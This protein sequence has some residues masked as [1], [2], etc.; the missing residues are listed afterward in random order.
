MT[1]NNLNEKIILRVCSIL[2]I[3]CYQGR[4]EEFV[5]RICEDIAA[6]NCVVIDSGNKSICSLHPTK[7]EL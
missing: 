5:L 7:Q 6:G 4:Q 1:E 2:D 3:P